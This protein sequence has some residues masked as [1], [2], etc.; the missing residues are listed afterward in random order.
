MKICWDTLEKIKFTIEGNF[1]DSTGNTYYEREACPICGEPT[2]NVRSVVL[3][4]L[5]TV[6]TMK[7]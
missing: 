2:M 5:Y 6:I 3:E 1:R 7:E 4:N